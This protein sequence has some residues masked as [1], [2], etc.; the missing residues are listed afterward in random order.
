M[1]G[2]TGFSLTWGLERRTPLGKCALSTAQ[3]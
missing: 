1:L 2:I 3:Q